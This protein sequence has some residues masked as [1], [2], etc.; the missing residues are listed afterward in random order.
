MPIITAAWRQ[1]LLTVAIGAAT[2]VIAGYTIFRSPLGN[3]LVTLNPCSILSGGKS[4][5]IVRGP[6]WL[7]LHEKRPVAKGSFML[8]PKFD[9]SSPHQSGDAYSQLPLRSRS[10]SIRSSKGFNTAGG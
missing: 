9:P 8:K 2:V 7:I 4:S 5:P 6:E 10:P 1:L 3:V